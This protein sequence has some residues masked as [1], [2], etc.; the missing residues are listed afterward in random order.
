MFRK[1]QYLLALARERH[2][3]RAAAL[4][5]VAQP[6]LSNAIRQLEE[7]LRVP[8]VERGHRFIK[9]T[10]EGEKVL[11]YARRV[12]G[13]FD[14]LMQDLGALGQELTGQLRLGV[15]PTA[16]P[17]VA[18]LVTPFAERHPGIRISISSLSSRQIQRGLDNF[19]LDAGITYLDNEPLTGVRMQPL[20][21]ERYFLLTHRERIAGQRTDITWA[22]ASA[23]PL[24]LLTPDM[25]NRRIADAA[26]RMAGRQ[27]A[28]AVETN[29]IINIFT[30]VQHGPWSSIV[31]GQLLTLMPLPPELIAFPL[32]MPDVTY[33]VG[34]VY[35]D[36]SPV[37]P[38][39]KA[40]ASVAAAEKLASRI[41]Q[42]V[43]DSLARHGIVWT[44]TRTTRSG[45]V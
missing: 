34:I 45:G 35:A 6:T 44:A 1:F 13:D 36:R 4:C 39:A 32:V 18:H 43:K 15:I 11:E 42:I 23:M 33:V 5:N 3:G 17:M 2:F 29:S 20:Y 12:S 41:P 25:Q 8:I 16:L 27:V 24:C 31:P 28:P 10:P 30:T 37:V 21:S 26:F 19:E 14:A 9:F 22:E 40:L 7:E 38:A